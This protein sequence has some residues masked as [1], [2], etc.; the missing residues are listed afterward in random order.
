[1]THQEE[2]PVF[3]HPSNVESVLPKFPESF[4]QLRTHHLAFQNLVCC[5]MHDD[6]PWWTPHTVC[7]VL[8][9]SMIMGLGNLASLASEHP[10]VT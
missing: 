4:S 2:V 8:Y 10:R 6:T 7:S 3:L 5:R 1:M 9:E